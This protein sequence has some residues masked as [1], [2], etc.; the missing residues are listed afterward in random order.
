[1]TVSVV[2][3]VWNGALH[4]AQ[5]VESVL[6]QE[7]PADEILVVDDG[8]TD[9]TPAVASRFPQVRYLRQENRGPG[10]ARNLGLRESRGSLVA[11]LDHDDLWLPGKL[12][13]QLDRLAQEPAADGVFAW[14]ENFL[15]GELPPEERLRLRCPEEPSRA[16]AASTL[17]VR[18]EVFDRVGPWPD[19]QREG[20]E[21]FQCARDAGVRLVEIPAVLA[22]RRLH[23]TN[24]TRIG[25]QHNQ[26]YLRI[27][28]ES[29]LR[30]R[31][32]ASAP[33]GPGSPPAP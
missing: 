18:R 3:P 20:V 11:F 30:K 8:S 15:S 14:M 13:A 22:R 12:G 21:W 32:A 23:L 27:A 33:P 29:L 25:S 16:P 31:R 2:I 7:H 4:L 5:A 6:A 10:P 19:S 24:R 9:G 26:D 17:L 1:M 28:R